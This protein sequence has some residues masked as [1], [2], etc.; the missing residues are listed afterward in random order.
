M[1]SESEM[2]AEEELNQI[3]FQYVNRGRPIRTVEDDGFQAIIRYSID[4][5][6]QLQNY[7]RM[8]RAKYTTIEC[9]NFAAFV[10]QVTHLV[11]KVRSLYAKIAGERQPF[12]SVAQDV[13]DGKR[14][15]INGLVIFFIDPE[16]CQ[17]YRIPIALLKPGGKSALELCSSCMLGLDKYGIEIDDLF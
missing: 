14:K 5:A 4:N 1:T 11:F 13:W 2:K 16:D 12:I 6:H 7:K 15:Q 10:A 8:G 17:I 9:S 3:I